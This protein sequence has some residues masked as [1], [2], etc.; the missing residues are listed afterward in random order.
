MLRHTWPCVLL[1]L[2]TSACDG[3]RTAP[4]SPAA[5][6]SPSPS[7]TFTFRGQV[8]T[9]GTRVPISEATVSVVSG[10]DAGKSATTD[11]SGS[12]SLTEMQQSSV[13][14]TASAAEY[15]SNNAP[16]ASNETQTIF[17]VPLGPVIQLSG[18]VTDAS[19]SAPIAA[20]S[21]HVNGRYRTTTDASGNYRLTGRL[22]NG[23]SSITWASADGYDTFTRYIRGD[24][25]QSFRL[26]PIERILGGD[27]WSVTI[28]PDDSLCFSDSYDPSFGRPGSGLRCRTVRVTT[29]STGML[30]I[31]A[32]STEDG[33]HPPLEVIPL[34]Y[35]PC[36]PQMENPISLNVQAGAELLVNVVGMSELSTAS[37]SF[38]VTTSMSP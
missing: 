36:C 2:L 19:T 32:V 26:R 31:E 16:L 21:V 34:K 37:Q 29:Q 3:D 8:I 33:S 11:A 27:S 20:A 14:V 28:H 12:F 35:S 18:R 30:R 7:R 38:I 6:M 23:D 9:S 1:M 15:F 25:A 4:T 13:F 17:L 5:P 10:P 22:D 24:S